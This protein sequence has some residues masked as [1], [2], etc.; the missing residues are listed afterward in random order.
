[1]SQSFT[2][3][4]LE[5]VRA[6]R[7]GRP[8]GLERVR[9]LRAGSY[10]IPEGGPGLS[11]P[12]QEDVGDFG[13]RPVTVD[14]P[15]QPTAYGNSMALAAAYGATPVQAAAAEG[16]KQRAMA[17]AATDPFAPPGVTPERRAQEVAGIG[18]REAGKTLN[19]MRMDE[20][21]AGQ[22]A[23]DE[24]AS[25]AR[26][27]GRLGASLEAGVGGAFE[28]GMSTLERLSGRAMPGQGPSTFAD[29]EMQAIADRADPLTKLAAGLATYP[30]QLA[31][32]PVV[33]IP[34]LLLGG[35]AGRAVS[36]GR[37]TAV[38]EATEAFLKGLAARIG[39]RA[40]QRVIPIAHSIMTSTGG[41]S[42]MSAASAAG[43]YP[44]WETDP[45]GG[46]RAMQEAAIHG[47][48]LGLGLGV[49]HGAANPLRLSPAVG[50]GRAPAAMENVTDVAGKERGPLP[51]LPQGR[52]PTPTPDAGQ[53]AK[54]AAPALRM[55][56]GTVLVAP[57]GSA[58]YAVA[59]AMERHGFKPEDVYDA[60]FHRE[61]DGYF[62]E[63]AERR[64][65]EAGQPFRTDPET[66][67]PVPKIG[68]VIDVEKPATPNVAEGLEPQTP[69]EAPRVQEEAQAAP[70]APGVLN[71]STVP[72]EPSRANPEGGAGPVHDR[73]DA[74][75]PPAVQGGQ[76]GGDG[77]KAQ[78]PPRVRPVPY[79]PA[80]QAERTFARAPRRGEFG[81]PDIERR[82]KKAAENLPDLGEVELAEHEQDRVGHDMFSTSFLGPIPA[83]L[84]EAIAGRPGL[85]LQLRANVPAA[86]N[87]MG[88]S[89]LEGLG[90]D[91]YVRRLTEM[92][93]GKTRRAKEAVQAQGH[94]YDPEAVFFADFHDR[95]PN[96]QPLGV[97]DQPERLPH[98]T[99]VKI[100]G[101]KFTVEHDSD[102]GDAFLVGE[103]ENDIPYAL[104]VFKSL[105][106]DPG[107]LEVPREG[108]A[109]RLRAEYVK[110]ADPVR[111]AVLAGELKE[112][113]VNLTAPEAKPAEKNL[114]GDTVVEPATGRQGEMVFET[115]SKIKRPARTGDDATIAAKFDEEATPTFDT[116][117][118]KESE[119]LPDLPEKP[120]DD[121][122]FA[123][124]G[125]PSP[126]HAQPRTMHGPAEPTVAVKDLHDAMQ[127]MANVPIRERSGHFAQR[128]AEG[129]FNRFT[130]SIRVRAWTD[131]DTKMHEVGHA[132]HDRF[133]GWNV[134]PPPKVK[135][136]LVALGRE[137]YGARKP[138]GGYMREGVAEWSARYMLSDPDL[139]TR[140]P[141]AT[142]WMEAEIARHP[143][144][145][146]D[147]ATTK[148]LF[149]EW[150]AQG[151]WARVAAQ[152]KKPGALDNTKAALERHATPEGF[153]RDWVEYARPMAEAQNRLMQE[154][155][156]DPA[157][158]APALKPYEALRA[159]RMTSPG[160]ARHFVEHEAVDIKGK[161]VG[162]G[163]AEVLEPVKDD[164]DRFSRYAVARRHQELRTRGK[165]DKTVSDADADYV[166]KTAP[167]EYEAVLKG[168]TG[169]YEDLLDYMVQG[170]ALSPEARAR[171]LDANSVYVPFQRY[172]DESHARVS[173]NT[174]TIGGGRGM[175]DRGPAVKRIGGAGEPV[176]DPLSTF[177]S[178]AQQMIAA[179]HKAMVME[180]AV[181]LAERVPK[182]AWFAEKVQGPTE[183]VRVTIGQ[184]RKDLEALGIDLTDIDEAALVT[185]WKE[186]PAYM[187]PDN[188]GM[189][190]RPNGER[191]FW[192]LAP[193]VFRVLKDMDRDVDVPAY[194]APLQPAKRALQLGATGLN[195]GFTIANLVRDAAA[196]AVYG[197]G[198]KFPGSATARGLIEQVAG[199]EYSRL[200][201]AMGGEMAS[202]MGQD[203]AAARRMVVEA[204][205]GTLYNI[206]RHPVDTAR[207]VLGAFELA[208][209][210]AEYKTALQKE[211]A[212]WG[213][214]SLSARIAAMIAA[215]D[216]TIDFTRAGTVGQS[217]NR[218]SAFFNA[219]IQGVDKFW[220]E[221]VKRPNR[222]LAKGFA[223]LTIPTIALWWLYKDEDWYRELPKQDRL[224]NWHV[225]IGDTIYK[226]PRPYELGQ[227]F[228]SAPEAIL[229]RLYDTGDE[230]FKRQLSDAVGEMVAQVMPLSRP[231]QFLRFIPPGLK[232]ALEVTTNRNFWNMEPIVPEFQAMNRPPEEQT[233][234]DTTELAR[235]M[236][237]AFNAS[238]AKVQHVMS[239]LTGGLAVDATKAVESIM[240]LSE[241]KPGSIPIVG[242]FIS[243]PPIG[244][245]SYTVEMF[246]DELQQAKQ[247]NGS[248]S[249]TTADKKRYR[250]LNRF[251][252]DMGE[253]RKQAESGRR[254]KADAD[255][256]I[257]RL[258]KRALEQASR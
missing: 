181:K 14:R 79:S 85:M 30:V 93:K 120:D 211:E 200:F 46:L 16:A 187:G 87:P 11:L 256:A 5:R 63:S 33:E 3:S 204:T 212:R 249:A 164:L 73:L 208:P 92:A 83:D 237:K 110:T 193:E 49:L 51:E 100:G 65:R 69:K 185:A 58:H 167:K 144:L 130:G 257:L 177:A 252:D 205:K 215:K 50:E 223:Y 103:G 201:K 47:A 55:K 123:P 202:I 186:A 218:I 184:I 231:G 235:A 61:G 203:R 44:N 117:S 48:G 113:G 221:G 246:Y 196:S 9:A 153:Y 115:E 105:P 189:L 236:G 228:A 159:V 233:R 199:G 148:R 39:P 82:L 6:L 239:G 111:K 89:V 15:V 97:I 216:A 162:P 23:A 180:A 183:Q 240:G 114:L 134:K 140:Y 172:F 81:K 142:A 13:G 160:I 45:E 207:N 22:K 198:W 145:A 194:L 258:A 121:I 102:Y 122:P 232:E 38:S 56:D 70:P 206:V 37:G 91:E 20:S 133:I 74:G 151:A 241:D 178:Q 251:A 68:R 169:W 28:T 247:K 119:S 197:T 209:R 36:V 163:L 60:G 4:Q 136:E 106:F 52:P 154:A 242:R 66:S 179:T 230:R 43:N 175:L 173:R 116:L 190:Y 10:Q 226:I 149:D 219:Q 210:I 135:K 94:G 95:Y 57:N 152:V 64:A 132:I 166:V 129:W 192:Q 243:R 234:P 86:R 104:S 195:I 225:K 40:S 248:E 141:N 176:L 238:P 224:N 21:L 171:I 139:A 188:I 253:L 96:E 125:A 1:M 170:G 108:M 118:E 124:S 2:A 107:T 54:R 8:S 67:G 147:W 222:M 53:G 131:L 25:R 109:A 213:K 27:V 138:N 90:V 41:L 150:D 12:E 182:A 128:K 127:R 143:E 191:E 155:G 72:Q 168:V 245:S 174:G 76:P 32:N 112:L 59:E 62:A 158:V 137:L 35:A 24:A 78:K 99:T 7:G 71:P 17:E 26:F 98:G 80:S 161:K 18:E 88:Q 220:R 77:G 29:P 229:N 217:V 254:K 255:A 165:P 227:V 146:K 84:K 244:S 42:A 31:A 101:E 19:R 157:K 75:Q 34:S 214:D 126:M 156:I 250:I